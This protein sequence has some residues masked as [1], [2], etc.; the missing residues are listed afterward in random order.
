MISEI[1]NNAKIAL[2]GKWRKAVC[3]ALA[4]FTFNI[5]L[6]LITSLFENKAIIRNIADILYII[7]TIPIV[8]GI[9]IA[10]IRLKRNENVKAF[11]F[12][13]LGFSNFG[14]AWGIAL[15][16][17]V[18]LLLPFLVMI[19][20]VTVLGVGI[21]IVEYVEMNV[22]ITTLLKLILLMFLLN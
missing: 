8:F 17:A 12:I 16:V 13:R 15:S 7:I 4:Y 11:D 9:T 19:I 6:N 5:V 20:A 2:A 18:K 22:V 14:R 1:K 3:M 21:G 10:G